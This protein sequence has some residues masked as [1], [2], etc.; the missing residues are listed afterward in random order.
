MENENIELRPESK[1]A[2]LEKSVET[3][4]SVSYKKGD[5]LK[6]RALYFV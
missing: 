5:L 1:A 6:I 2:G 3:E 4:T